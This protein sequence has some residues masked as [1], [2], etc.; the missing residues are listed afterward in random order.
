MTEEILIESTPFGTLHFPAKEGL[1]ENRT[2][3]LGGRPRVVELYIGQDLARSPGQEAVA[4]LLNAVPELYQK[5]MERILRDCETDPAIAG[6][7]QRRIDEAGGEE[8]LFSI[9]IDFASMEALSHRKVFAAELEP[10]G[11][12]ILPGGEGKLCCAILFYH[13]PVLFG[14]YLV[15][16]FG[17]DGELI[18]IFSIAGGTEDGGESLA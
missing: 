5:A 7:L 15:A 10:E 16:R 4:A 17:Q 2:V 12:M 1:D 13:D 9:A 11:I 6:Y 3:T 8:D 14:E 18:H